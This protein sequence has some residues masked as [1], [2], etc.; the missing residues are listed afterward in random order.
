MS[1]RITLIEGSSTD[2]ATLRQVR[3][4][5]NPDDSVL[6]LLD[7]DH[8]RDHVRAELEMHAPLVSPGGYIVVFDSVMTMVHD[9]PNGNR[10]WSDDN[11]ATAVT[12]F[13]EAHPE[14]S[15]DEAYERLE[16]TYC[17]GGFLRR[18]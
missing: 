2:E 11:P 18:S 6:V 15:R 7:S 1:K 4:R 10:A 9:A 16:V 13:L 8:T 17:R 12:D 14:F 5:I 3:A